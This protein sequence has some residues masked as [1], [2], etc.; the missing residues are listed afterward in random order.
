MLGAQSDDPLGHAGQLSHQVKGS[1]QGGAARLFP[2]FMQQSRFDLYTPHAL[3][4][5]GIIGAIAGSIG[6]CIDILLAR[7]GRFKPT[8]WGLIGFV[9]G[10][11][12][13][14]FYGPIL[15]VLIMFGI[16]ILWN[17]SS[18]GKQE[19]RKNSIRLS[20]IFGVIFLVIA[21]YQVLSRT[22]ISP[23][24]T[25]FL[26]IKLAVMWML[27]WFAIPILWILTNK[28][29]NNILRW[30]CRVTLI[31]IAAFS[32]FIFVVS[33]LGIGPIGCM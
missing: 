9:L 3:I 28:I 26:G 1:K 19:S 8:W 30:I 32:I 12:F 11:G 16:P 5:P 31:F 27:I 14:F 22:M 13:G 25:I 20:L 23:E 18:M 4:N 2:L 17:V 10:S 24:A 29:P 33:C 15:L 7:S 6:G 21:T